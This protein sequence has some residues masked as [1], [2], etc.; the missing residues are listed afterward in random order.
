MAFF[1][2]NPSADN[3][4]A[5]T[6][7]Q[8]SWSVA[9]GPAADHRRWVGI[10]SA[11]LDAGAFRLPLL[12]SRC[13]PLLPLALPPT[14]CTPPFPSPALPPGASSTPMGEQPTCAK[15]PVMRS[16]ERG[17]I[18]VDKQASLWIEQRGKDPRA[19]SIVNEQ[20]RFLVDERRGDPRRQ[21]SFVVDEP[22]PVSMV[23]L[24]HTSMGSLVH[25]CARPTGSLCTRVPSP[26]CEG[27]R[28]SGN[29]GRRPP[30]AAGAPT[31][32]GSGLALAV[33]KS[34]LLRLLVLVWA[35][36]HRVHELLQPSLR[37]VQQQRERE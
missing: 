22:Q 11:R 30:T 3:S 8:K 1:P 12:P 7:R 29:C 18:L 5:K 17:K 25:T 24:V 20:T 16:V 6:P 2:S 34:V 32:C 35:G 10:E 4:M 15:T 26:L 28:R 23:S 13:E 14:G 31:G 37:A 27:E 19:S 21:A 33:C 36:L 9:A